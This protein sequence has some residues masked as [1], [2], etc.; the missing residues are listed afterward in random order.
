MAF[1]LAWSGET[2]SRALLYAALAHKPDQMRGQYV[3]P[4]RVDEPSDF[5]L[6]KDGKAAQ[7]RLW[8]SAVLC[9]LTPDVY[10]FQNETISKLSAASP[11]IQ[12]IVNS[13]LRG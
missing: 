6:S 11:L 13:Q 4:F 9:V 10:Y 12:D 3:N 7:G 5:V 8:V 1:F 2:G